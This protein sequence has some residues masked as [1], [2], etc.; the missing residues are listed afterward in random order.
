MSNRVSNYSLVLLIE[1][2]ELAATT[3]VHYTDALK[4]C[5]IYFHRAGFLQRR[6]KLKELKLTIKVI[7]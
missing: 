2:T 5:S 6:Q 3:F 4:L 7:I 1:Q